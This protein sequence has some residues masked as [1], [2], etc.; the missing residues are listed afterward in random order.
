MLIGNHVKLPNTPNPQESQGSSYFSKRGKPILFQVIDPMNQPLWPYLLALHVNPNSF[1]ES[2][3]KSKSVSMTYG[4]FV[5][6]MW[7]DELDDI[8]ASASTGAFLGP[9]SGL[10]SGSDGEDQGLHS[11]HQGITGRQG[12]MAWERQEDLLDLFRNNGAIYNGS[13]QPILRGRIMCIY[14]RGIYTGHFTTFSPKE[15]DNHAFSFEL[16]WNFKIEHTIYL[17]SGSRTNLKSV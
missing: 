7:P 6:F 17:F 11:S 1:N 2:F 9:F 4:G 12:T 10:T 13:G 16:S 14:D 5:E 3:N 15:D 8:N